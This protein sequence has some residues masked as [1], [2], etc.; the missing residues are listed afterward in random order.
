MAMLQ[1]YGWRMVDP[2]GPPRF[3][4]P[5]TAWQLDPATNDYIA[6]PPQEDDR[7]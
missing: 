5:A 7:R 1:R 6:P 3:L 2:D 4:H